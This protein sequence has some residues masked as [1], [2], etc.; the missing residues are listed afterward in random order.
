MFG[1]LFYEGTRVAF[2]VNLKKLEKELHVSSLHSFLLESS[3]GL[4][5]RGRLNEKIVCYMTLMVLAS[6]F[7]LVQVIFDVVRP[8]S[9]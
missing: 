1:L 9:C 4:I 3:L 7:K 5:G 6:W 8:P 2:S